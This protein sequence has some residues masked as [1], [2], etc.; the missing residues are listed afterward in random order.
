HDHVGVVLA[1]VEVE[2]KGQAQIE[3]FVHGPAAGLVDA[4]GNTAKT[5]A[6]GAVEYQDAGQLGDQVLVGQVERLVAHQIAEKAAD[7]GPFGL[8]LAL[9]MP[10]GAHDQ[11]PRGGREDVVGKDIV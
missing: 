3:G 1:L 5:D 2:L 4:L 8:A 11:A 10:H 7:I 9:G 6:S